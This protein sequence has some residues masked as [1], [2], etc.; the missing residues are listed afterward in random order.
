MC[1]T[2][3]AER[4][5]GRLLESEEAIAALIQQAAQEHGASDCIAISAHPDRM[6]EV[7]RAGAAGRLAGLENAKLRP[8]PNL[9]P[10][11]LVLEYGEF[12]VDYGLKTIV[13]NGVAALRTGGAR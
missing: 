9:G 8:D 13:A 4:V 12:A 5:F 11:D 1:L 3:L 10:D 6:A 7:A 2:L